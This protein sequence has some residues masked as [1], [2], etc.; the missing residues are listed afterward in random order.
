MKKRK[1]MAVPKAQKGLKGVKLKG[2]NQRSI[3]C[4]RLLGDLLYL[5][6]QKN[7]V[8]FRASSDHW[9]SPTLLISLDTLV[10]ECELQKPDYKGSIR[11]LVEC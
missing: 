1:E 3:E 8:G 2:L 10:N 11:E 9:I 7:Q 4:K 6:G 5:M